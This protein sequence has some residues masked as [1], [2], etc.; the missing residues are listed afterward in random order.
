MFLFVYF[1]ATLTTSLKFAATILSFALWP[2]LSLFLICEV[3][4]S[5]L[6][7]FINRIKSESS[8]RYNSKIYNETEFSSRNIKEVLPTYDASSEEVDG[9]IVLRDNFDQILMHTA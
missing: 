6:V 1:L 8:F 5:N 4:K 7:N 3:D 9:R 2:A